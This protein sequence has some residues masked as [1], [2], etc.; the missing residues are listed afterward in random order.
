M[1]ALLLLILLAALWY[2]LAFLP[3][4]RELWLR[5]DV[6]PL[7]VI[8]EYDGSAAYFARSSLAFIS[9]N[10]PGKITR[11][12]NQRIEGVLD[13]GTPYTMLPFSEQTRVLRVAECERALFLRA[14]HIFWLVRRHQCLGFSSVAGRI[15]QR[16]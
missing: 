3:A 5:T 2:L 11:E 15:P 10:F 16:K 12:E 13:N 4:L 1:T 6:R 8:G 9:A 14:K 7:R